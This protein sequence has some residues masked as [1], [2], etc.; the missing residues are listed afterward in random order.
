MAEGS[1]KRGKP[2]DLDDLLGDIGLDAIPD[3]DPSIFDI[4]GNDEL[5]PQ[6]RYTK[7][8][9]FRSPA[10][11]VCYDNAVRLAREIRIGKGERTDLFVNG[12]FIFGDFIEA[13]LTSH[14]LKADR[15]I[16]STLSMSQDNVDSLR[17]LMDKGYLDRLDLIISAYFFANERSALIPYIY[18]ELDV[19]DRFQLAVAGIHT[20]TCQFV[21]APECGAD[22]IVIHGSANLR[23][24]GNVEQITVES[25]SELYDFYEEHFRKILDS[26]ATI[27]KP[28]RHDDLWA[29]MIRKQFDGNEG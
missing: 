22:K 17:T 26:Y 13:Y 9:A 3:F 24:S 14:N 1:G 7:P 20:K 11:F 28:I 19:G 5:A 6:T 16:I 4:G 18:R 25:N 2:Q 23:S 15:M 29:A 12:S 8:K 27:R 21:T 10:R